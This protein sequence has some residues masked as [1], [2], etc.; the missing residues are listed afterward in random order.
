MPHTH[1]YP[2]EFTETSVQNQSSEKCTNSVSG[3]NSCLSCPLYTM[4]SNPKRARRAGM[5]VQEDDKNCQCDC[6]GILSI[7]GL[8]DTRI[9]DEW[10]EGGTIRGNHV[11][12]VSGFGFLC[13]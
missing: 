13:F 9:T 10:A 1:K 4:F 7:V 5:Y 12:G 2:S 8:G 3:G 6:M 11:L